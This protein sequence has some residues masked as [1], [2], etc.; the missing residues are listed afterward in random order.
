VHGASLIS[1]SSTLIPGLSNL[2]PS[3]YTLHPTP[4]TLH[5]TPQTL[6]PEANTL[7]Q[8][9]ATHP[10]Y[11]GTVHGAFMAGERE[12]DRVLSHDAMDSS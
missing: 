4:Y 7:N 8:G 5:P 2:H 1:R 12:A 9:E 10:N 6:S 3:P 11:F